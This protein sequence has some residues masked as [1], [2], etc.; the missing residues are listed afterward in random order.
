MRD[1]Q[2]DRFDV[3]DRAVALG[4]CSRRRDGHVDAG[5]QLEV[6]H[7]D[8]CERNAVCTDIC[9]RRFKLSAVRAE[10]DQSLRSRS[11][12]DDERGGRRAVVPWREVDGHRHRRALGDDHVGGGV[13]GLGELLG[14]DRHRALVGDDQPAYDRDIVDLNAALRRSALDA[15]VAG[16]A[17]RCDHIVRSVLHRQ[18]GGVDDDARVALP[19]DARD[20]VRGVGRV[21]RQVAAGD[22]GG[23]FLRSGGDRRARKRRRAVIGL[24]DGSYLDCRRSDRIDGGML[25]ADDVAVL[26]RLSGR[27]AFGEHRDDRVGRDGVVA[28]LFGERGRPYEIF[29]DEQAVNAG[30]LRGARPLV[31]AVEQR[32]DDGLVKCD[33]GRLIVFVGDGDGQ[34]DRLIADRGTCVPLLAVSLRVECGGDEHVA[35]GEAGVGI[36]GVL[37]AAGDGLLDDLEHA[38]R[39]TLIEREIV[40]VERDGDRIFADARQLGVARDGHRERERG[41][42]ADLRRTARDVSVGKA[43][44]HVAEAEHHV[45]D[46]VRRAGA[47][48]ELRAVD[49]LAHRLVRR[50]RRIA[51]NICRYLIGADEI[52]VDVSGGDHGGV[53]AAVGV[54]DEVVD[55]FASDCEDVII[56]SAD[57]VAHR[58]E[59][60]VSARLRLGLEIVRFAGKVL[61]AGRVDDAVDVEDGLVAVGVGGVGVVKLLGYRID[62]DGR[63]RDRER[64][65][66]IS[67][68]ISIVDLV[69]CGQRDADRGG[70]VADRQSAVHRIRTAESDVGRVGNRGLERELISVFIRHGRRNFDVLSAAVVDVGIAA[71]HDRVRLVGDDLSVDRELKLELAVGGGVEAVRP[72]VVRLT[73][74]DADDGQGD[75]IGA[76]VAVAAAL[77]GDRDVDDLGDVVLVAPAASLLG[78]A[79]RELVVAV[80]GELAA[81]AERRTLYGEVVLFA[82]PLLD[83]R[84]REVFALYRIL[85]DDA[86]SAEGVVGD[87]VV[88]REVVA[89]GRVG[90]VGAVMLACDEDVEGV[91]VYADAVGLHRHVL[92]LADARVDERA[93]GSDHRVGSESGYRDLGFVRIAVV[94]ISSAAIQHPDPG[95]LHLDRSDAAHVDGGVF[96]EVVD[97]GVVALYVKCL[98]FGAA[99]RDRRGRQLEGLAVACG[100]IAVGIFADEHYALVVRNRSCAARIGEDRI[101]CLLAGAVVLLDNG[102]ELYQFGSDVQARALYIY[103]E[104]RDAARQHIVVGLEVGDRHGERIA[105][106]ADIDRVA[107]DGIGELVGRVV[108]VQHIS[109]GI[110]HGQRSVEQ[111]G[112]C[113]G[114]CA[115][116]DAEDVLHRVGERRLLNDYLG[117]DER[118]DVQRRGLQDIV[119]VCRNK[120]DRGLVFAL[121]PDGLR[122]S[123]QIGQR[124]AVVVGEHSGDHAVAVESRAARCGAGDVHGRPL[125]RR[126]GIVVVVAVLHLSF[127]GVRPA[128][129]VARAVRDKEGEVVQSELVGRDRGIGAVEAD[130]T[131]VVIAID[132]CGDCLSVRK[133]LSDHR[134][135]G[136]VA[137]RVADE[138][139][140]VLRDGRARSAAVDGAE[141][142]HVSV[143]G[144]EPLFALILAGER[145]SYQEPYGRFFRRG[146][147]GERGARH[148]VGAVIDLGHADPADPGRQDR[149]VEVVIVRAD[150]EH[151]GALR[152]VDFE[153]C[154]RARFVLKQQA[155]VVLPCVA[156][157][158]RQPVGRLQVA[159]RIRDELVEIEHVL[160][161]HG[162]IVQHLDRGIFVADIVQRRQI[163]LRAVVDVRLRVVVGQRFD[164]GLS[165]LVLA[166]P[167]HRVVTVEVG[168][169]RDG[170]ADPIGDP[171]VD[172][173]VVAAHRAVELVVCHRLLERVDGVVVVGGI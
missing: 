89:L 125:E 120:G 92:A 95:D 154:V 56:F 122:P 133:P 22:R 167:H 121:V 44:S 103:V 60:D 96:D 28:E 130:G 43:V 141:E 126:L 20:A 90:A 149:R 13:I 59:G 111:V 142:H 164:D 53:V 145:T 99:Q 81:R 71:V 41:D 61:R 29:V 80:I 163:E 30:D 110:G 64:N 98:E 79:A 31:D 4:V 26:T 9:R 93:F 151:D 3:V 97:V 166:D 135:V 157:R 82:V 117:D 33:L 158:P 109:V 136:R 156:R 6:A 129:F 131:A 134:E 124:H 139:D 11:Q 137:V 86:D 119:A 36:I 15:I 52:L 17:A 101:V 113:V 172:A 168:R 159:V 91:V 5:R 48:L 127:V 155:Y 2:L 106:L 116:I 42:V 57:V 54:L 72:F 75:D 112:G 25:R 10:E 162:G 47:V 171:D 173:V 77:A 152:R 114:L 1:R 87:I 34:D 143:V 66:R 148:L 49:R 68:G 46:G 85:I 14:G 63:R 165:I 19:F 70:I 105:V 146:G 138:H 170:G 7:A 51:V 104:R 67:A 140:L 27:R 144:G 108:G 160:G 153:P 78:C 88:A 23:D 84:N 45:R 76:G 18:S 32:R 38:V 12:R 100:Q 128:P 55:L 94:E 39:R 35:A 40:V 118:A 74:V 24:V 8:G 73:A 107:V 169:D 50:A 147:V 83:D 102:L 65:C 37:R 16:D 150:A 123:E 161:K 69:V 58:R 115:V 21:G 132:V 62:G